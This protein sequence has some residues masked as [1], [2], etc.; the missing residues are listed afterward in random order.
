MRRPFRLR[1]FA[2]GL[3]AVLIQVLAPGLAAVAMA[4]QFDPLAGVPICSVDHAQEEDADRPANGHHVFCPLCIVCSLGHGR[5][6]L[7]PAVI[8]E[9]PELPLPQIGLPV[10]H[11]H[12]DVAAPRG[13]PAPTAQARGPPSLS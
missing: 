7:Q 2:I 4:S 12:V 10:R 3:F 6:A 8:A 5:G 1:F 13:P 11:P 9:A